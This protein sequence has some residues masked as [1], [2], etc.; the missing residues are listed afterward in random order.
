MKRLKGEGN[1]SSYFNNDDVTYIWMPNF[2]FDFGQEKIELWGKVSYF[3]TAKQ[4]GLETD[5]L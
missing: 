5:R 3:C 4:N 1:F 2:G